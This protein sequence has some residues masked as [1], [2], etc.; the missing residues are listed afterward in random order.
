MAAHMLPIMDY[1]ASAD[2]I[3][4]RAADILPSLP[5]KDAKVAAA[6]AAVEL[7]QNR[8]AGAIE[9]A[10]AEAVDGVNA[11]DGD[12]AE[13]GENYQQFIE[14]AAFE[15]AT[16][17]AAKDAL[18]SEF[19]ALVVGIRFDDAGMA[20]AVADAIAARL[21]PKWEPLPMHRG[22]FLSKLGIVAEH[23]E[24]ITAPPAEAEP[25]PFT[26]AVAEYNADTGEFNDPAQNAVLASLPFVEL[27]GLSLPTKA[28]PPDD[29]TNLQLGVPD[30]DELRRGYHA[31][32]Q[33]CGPDMDAA[34]KALGISSQTLNNWCR[35]NKVKPK[36]SAAQA[37]VI[38]RFIDESRALLR[39]AE[40]IFSRCR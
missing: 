1:A 19:D 9:A 22:K 23:L 40:L 36:C 3:V 33:G 12:R 17:R 11:V 4:H 2:E 7:A 15:H 10:L 29:L 28:P 30:T 20:G 8:L 25:E 24:R 32:Y 16:I 34:A 6:R 21:A 18:P 35:H 13:V 38:L 39:E 27:P 37:D 5:N 31:W 26:E 14:N